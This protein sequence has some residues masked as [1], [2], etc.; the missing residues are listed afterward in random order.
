MLPTRGDQNAKCLDGFLWFL[1]RN[2]ALRPCYTRLSAILTH[3]G[4]LQPM[5]TGN[6]RKR[7]LSWPVPLAVISNVV[8]QIAS[9]IG[10][11]GWH[12]APWCPWWC[13]FAPSRMDRCEDIVARGN[14]KA[15]AL[16]RVPAAFSAGRYLL[17]ICPPWCPLLRPCHAAPETAERNGRSDTEYRK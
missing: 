2:Q 3:S 13:C 15:L 10:E 9:L 11:R 1:Q 7:W 6:T 12:V 14:T 4:E 5:F 16:T 8:T 17:V